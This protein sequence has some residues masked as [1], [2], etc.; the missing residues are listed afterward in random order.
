MRIYYNLF[1]PVLRQIERTAVLR[2]N[3]TVSIK[4]EQDRAR[5]PLQRLLAADPPISREAQAPFAAPPNH[6]PARTQA[7]HPRPD[8]SADRY[9]NPITKGGGICSGMIIC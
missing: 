8:P 1:Q 9:V 6:Q 4:R 3:G 5:T 7:P 2:P